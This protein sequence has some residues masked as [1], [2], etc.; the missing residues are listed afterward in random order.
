M[1]SVISSKEARELISN[2]AQIVDVR[3]VHEFKQDAIRGAVNLPL[4]DLNNNLSGLDS[5]KPVLVYCRTGGRSAKAQQVL[6]SK[7]FTVHN[8]GSLSNLSW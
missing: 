3:S 5:T 7:G 4:G 1:K 6:T 8:A 2:G